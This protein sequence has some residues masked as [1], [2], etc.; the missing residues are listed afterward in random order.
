VKT[1]II[2]LEPYDDI[3]STQD[4]MSWGKPARILLVWPARGRV[5]D[6]QLNLILLKR[7]SAE[8][9]AQL[10]LVTHDA[11]VRF[12]AQHLGIPVYNHVRKAEQSHWRSKQRFSR[13]RP[14][15]I[16]R[17]SPIHLRKKLPPD[18]AALRL[19]ANPGSPAWIANS[20]VRVAAFVLGVLAILAIAALLL[21]S[22][23]IQ[24]TPKI[25]DQNITIS[26][27][28]N[29]EVEKVNL[30]GSI[31]VRWQ[32]VIVEGRAQIDSSGSIAIPNQF[33]SGKVLFT[34][35]SDREIPIPIGT[36]IST[37]GAN[38][39]RFM[40]IEEGLLAVNAQE[41]TIE[42]RAT[43]A[44]SNG[45]VSVG[46]IIAIDGELGLN[47]IV[48]NPSGTHGGTDRTAPAPSQNNYQQLY[49]TLFQTLLASAAEEFQAGITTENLLLSTI[50]L[51]SEMI[52]E[53]YKPEKPEPADQ[54]QLLL[55][56]AFQIPTV[57]HTDLQL[58]GQ[59]ALE[60]NLAPGYRSLS[61]TL[62]ISNLSAPTW[63]IETQKADWQIE[64]Y[65]Q[66]EEQINTQQVIHLTLGLPIPDAKNQLSQG[67]SL[68]TPASITMQPAW[69]PRLPFLPFRISVNS[70]NP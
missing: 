35:L 11:N 44:G 21:P 62:I 59:R 66:T 7:Y 48:Y 51:H 67:L 43:L 27:T 61:E 58:L 5:L 38:P 56:A 64:A 60:A 23:Q 18:L 39:I 3:S 70:D 2:Q 34:N 8:R 63:D 50:P 25:Q 17:L 6:T 15:T 42:I 49:D 33:S 19:D 22:A 14:R 32:S 55:R 10:A 69:W 12:H 52:E 45:N 9:G 47:L 24:L 68:K 28:A 16:K 41:V 57:S 26:V 4:K 13:Q 29:P 65:W 1:K 36:T 40:T 37:H 54:L 53:I 20:A 30:S 31:P 46:K